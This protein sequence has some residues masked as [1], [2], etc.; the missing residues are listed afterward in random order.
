MSNATYDVIWR[1]AQTSLEEVMQLDSL[2]QASASARERGEARAQVADLYVR[3]IDLGNRLE[4]C[5]DRVVQPQKRA[6]LR[7]LLDS[8]YGR[9]L[10]LK[11]ELVELELDEYNYFD[12]A[13]L[14]LRFYFFH[15]RCGGCDAY[16]YAFTNNII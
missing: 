9:V 14:K 7:R 1:E 15:P 12:E 5:Y 8:A 4:L 2:A 13:L 3:Y 10:E 11:H 6:L 16:A